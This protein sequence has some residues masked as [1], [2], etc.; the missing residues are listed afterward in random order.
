MRSFFSAF[1]IL[2]LFNAISLD[3]KSCSA[4]DREFKQRVK[5]LKA[6]WAREDDSLEKR[7][8]TV[9]K[10]ITALDKTFSKEVDALMKKMR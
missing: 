7:L 4:V 8:S 2:F 10:K 1:F 3:A 6:R 5:T 9:E